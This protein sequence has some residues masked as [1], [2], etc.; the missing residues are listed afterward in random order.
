MAKKKAPAKKAPA[1]KAPAKKAPA[2]KAAK[3]R[4]S[5][6][7][8]AEYDKMMNSGYMFAAREMNSDA[9]RANQRANM[10]MTPGMGLGGRRTAKG[11][12]PRPLNPNRRNAK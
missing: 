10:Y 1:K 4:A 11:P 3:G 7:S 6:I 9:V 5:E 8:R 12:P 2:K